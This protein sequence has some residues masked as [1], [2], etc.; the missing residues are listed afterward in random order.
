M[1]TKAVVDHLSLTLDADLEGMR[2]FARAE[3]RLRNGFERDS[4]RDALPI[5]TISSL[6]EIDPGR[7]RTLPN[8]KNDTYVGM[9]RLERLIRGNAGT[10]LPPNFGRKRHVRVGHGDYPW[11]STKKKRARRP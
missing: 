2:E 6:D 1:A 10:W 5:R 4:L 3:A 9:M 8:S 7:M 11:Y